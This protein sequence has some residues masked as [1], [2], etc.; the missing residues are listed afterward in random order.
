MELVNSHGQDR[1]STLL[2]ER[3]LTKETFFEKRYQLYT[4]QNW[5]EYEEGFGIPGK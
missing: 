2:K 3:E 5:T 4:E 1:I